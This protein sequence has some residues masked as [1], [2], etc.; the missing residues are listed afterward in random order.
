MLMFIR[1]KHTATVRILPH[2]QG[3]FPTL[4]ADLLTALVLSGMLPPTEGHKCTKNRPVS[5]R[6]N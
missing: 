5:A 1:D 2:S 4:L 3:F 6:E